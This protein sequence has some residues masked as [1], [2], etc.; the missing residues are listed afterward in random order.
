MKGLSS[1]HRIK[2]WELGFWV[3]MGLEF[4]KRVQKRMGNRN[5]TCSVLARALAK[6]L[7]GIR[8]SGVTYMMGVVRFLSIF[9]F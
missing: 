8:N 6:I 4:G 5:W 7:S 1:V 2:L 3:F 9:Q